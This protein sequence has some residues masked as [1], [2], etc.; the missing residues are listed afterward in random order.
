MPSKKSGGKRAVEKKH[1]EREA[2]NPAYKARCMA[3]RRRLPAPPKDPRAL[4]GMIPVRLAYLA[5]EAERDPRLPPETSREQAARFW[6]MAGK[7]IDAAKLRAELDELIVES[8]RDDH[9]ASPVD[10]IEAGDS[11]PAPR[12]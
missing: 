9:H 10:G 8:N 7:T 1:R 3:A 12:H 2:A 5:M 6:A 11:P 4:A